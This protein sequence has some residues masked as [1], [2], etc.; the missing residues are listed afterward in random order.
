MAES[1][2]RRPT[3]FTLKQ[4]APVRPRKR[5]PWFESGRLPVASRRP[6]VLASYLAACRSCGL[7][8]RSHGAPGFCP[9]CGEALD[10]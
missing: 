3:R 10:V 7:R 8:Y 5:A 1:T 6:F 2:A 4:T 9:E